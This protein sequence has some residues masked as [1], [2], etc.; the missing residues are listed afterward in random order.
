MLEAHFVTFVSPGTFVHEETTR[1]IDRWDINAAL[2]MARE[3]KE[4]HSATPFAFRFST[5]RREDSDLDSRV[6]K[7]SGRY[8]LGGTVLTLDEIKARN[9]PKDAVLI[10]NMEC[11]KWGRVIENCN[12]WK[13]TQP[14]EDDDTV[15]DFTPVLAD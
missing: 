12:S 8:Y 13:V 3:I 5:R 4:R 1:P 9:D 15:L 11:N 10:S 7:Q 14:L 2:K 6:V